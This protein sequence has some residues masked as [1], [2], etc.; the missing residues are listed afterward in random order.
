MWIHQDDT[1]IVNICATN[2]GILKCIRQILRDLKGVL[3]KNIAIVEDFNT[4][5]NSSE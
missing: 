1:I 5:L 3:D 2:I 4:T